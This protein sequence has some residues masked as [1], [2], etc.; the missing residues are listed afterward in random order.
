MRS[1]VYAFIAL[2]LGTLTPAAAQYYSPESEGSRSGAPRYYT[3]RPPSRGPEQGFDRRPYRNEPDGR[4][5]RDDRANDSYRQRDDRPGE[6]RPRSGPP[7]DNPAE[8][9]PSASYRGADPRPSSAAYRRFWDDRS[10]RRARTGARPADRRD[11]APP[12]RFTDRRPAGPAP[13]SGV[14]PGKMVISVAEYR[15]LQN[16]ARELQRLLGRRSDRRNDQPGPGPAYY[17]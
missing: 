6:F 5:P 17:R 10:D 12:R 16:Q 4:G 2:S 3:E 14:G 8:R 13:R 9:R 11:A 15:D 1:V 7:A